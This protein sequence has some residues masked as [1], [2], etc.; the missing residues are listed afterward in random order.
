L[1]D[2]LC[3]KVLDK[4]EKRKIREKKE[5]SL[6]SKEFSLADNQPSFKNTEKLE[7]NGNKKIIA[8]T[9]INS[10]ND[11]D[12]N[13]GNKMVNSCNNN[14]KADAKVITK[15]KLFKNG[16]LPNILRNPVHIHVRVELPLVILVLASFI[17]FTMITFLTIPTL[18]Y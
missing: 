6:A 8:T 5:A 1:G 14:L 16:L 11:D 4:W 9:S 15:R 10:N 17:L 7:K 2:V 18:I 3:Q 13:H 12:T